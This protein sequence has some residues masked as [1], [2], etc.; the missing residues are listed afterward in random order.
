VHT[1]S[2]HLRVSRSIEREYESRALLLLVVQKQFQSVLLATKKTSL[3]LRS[4][5]EPTP[6]LVLSWLFD[7]YLR[8]DTLLVE[9]LRRYSTRHNSKCNVVLAHHLLFHCSSCLERTGVDFLSSVGT[10]SHILAVQKQLFG[11]LHASQTDHIVL[12]FIP[13]QPGWYLCD[14]KIAPLEFHSHPEAW[15]LYSTWR[16]RR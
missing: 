10:G 11:I 12:R 13:R 14:T 8:Y 6:P 7:Q 3:S 15:C 5:P 4:L 2:E 1:F 16:M 9:Y